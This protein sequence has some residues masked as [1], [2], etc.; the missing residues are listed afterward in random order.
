MSDIVTFDAQG[1]IDAD[2][3]TGAEIEPHTIVVWFGTPG[4]PT[5]L[6][7]QDF[8]QSEDSGEVSVAGRVQENWDKGKTYLADAFMIQSAGVDTVA[9]DRLHL[10][11]FAIIANLTV[12]QIGFF[13]LADTTPET[14]VKLGLYRERS[15]QTAIDLIGEWDM[16]PADGFHQ[17]TTISPSLFLES[18]MY[19]IASASNNDDLRMTGYSAL[20]NAHPLMPASQTGRWSAAYIDK[21]ADWEQGLPT[22]IPWSSIQRSTS[23]F[24]PMPVLRV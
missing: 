8:W 19:Y 6:E 11:P 1:D 2:R 14:A 21:P 4:K 24:N 23:T 17:W 3:P 10:N 22:S 13:Q 12:S 9:A 7:P 15:D 18:D 5:N 20:G 16:D